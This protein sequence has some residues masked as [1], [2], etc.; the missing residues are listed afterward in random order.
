[1]DGALASIK[2]AVERKQNFEE[3]GYVLLPS[4]KTAYPHWKG[5]EV[6]E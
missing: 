3:M 2:D 5:E 6:T 1:M 4:Q